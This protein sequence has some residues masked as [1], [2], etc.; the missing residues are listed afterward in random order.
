M[1]RGKQSAAV[2]EALGWASRIIAVGLVMVLP[3]VAGGVLDARLGTAW[4]GPVGLGLGFVAGLAW[5]VRIA[6]GRGRP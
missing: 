2:G 3:M 1:A 5:L 6:A 4:L